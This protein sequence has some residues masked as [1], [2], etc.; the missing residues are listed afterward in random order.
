MNINILKFI[1]NDNERIIIPLD[2]PNDIIDYSYI[3]KAEL[4]IHDRITIIGSGA[5]GMQAIELQRLLEPV[6]AGRRP[7][8]ESIKKSIGYYY[9][10]DLNE[11]NPDIFLI[12]GKE[13]K[14]WIGSQYL[15]WTT[16]ST[17][18]NEQFATWLYNDASGNIVF[19]V[20]PIY[21]EDYVDLEDPVEVKVYQEWMEMSYKSFFTCIIPKE[22]AIQWLDQTNLI[23]KTIDQNIKMLKAQ[24][25][26]ESN[27]NL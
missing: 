19:E 3:A 12:Q 26:S 7:L 4:I 16:D 25:E 14:Y 1:I 10:Q 23:L 24:C 11:D 18:K 17:N 8:H 20:T 27:N 2:E 15:L 21:P 9:N 6:I 22:M 5:I 13:S